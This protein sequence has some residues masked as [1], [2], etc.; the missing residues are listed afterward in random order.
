[1]HNEQQPAY[2]TPHPPQGRDAATDAEHACST[3]AGD[4]HGPAPDNG[5]AQNPGQA[6][7]QSQGQFHA[8]Q[9]GAQAGM[10]GA[11]Q[12]QGNGAPSQAGMM[13]AGYPMQPGTAYQPGPNMGQP[14]FSAQFPGAAPYQ[15]APMAGGNGV[16]GQAYGQQGAQPSSA[17][18]AGFPQQPLGQAGYP[19]A[20]N[21]LPPQ[22]G[23]G[24]TAYQHPGTQPHPSQAAPSPGNG[25]ENRYGELYGL[26]QEA[27]NGNADVSGFLRFFQ[28]TSSDFWKGALVGTGLTL[29]LTNDTLKSAISKGFAGVFGLMGKSA[30]DMEAEEDRKAEQRA[31]KEDRT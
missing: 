14:H 24:A 20:M 3:S 25:Q 26:I 6:F 19:Y 15:G 30:E 16:Q 27:A 10:Y 17:Q 23:P 8:P 21:P 13:Q 2:P 29:L 18:P 31:A 1:M 28:S 7:A 9:P 4:A 11:P 12:G 5:P 22:A